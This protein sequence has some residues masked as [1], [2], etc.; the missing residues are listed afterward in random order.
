M[1]LFEWREMD[2]TEENNYYNANKLQKVILFTQH[3]P[4]PYSLRREMKKYLQFSF[5]F[6]WSWRFFF[7]S[8]IFS[9]YWV[10]C[11]MYEDWILL[12]CT[13]SL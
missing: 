10:P 12:T 2:G 9:L 1:T 11:C 4:N 5:V 6:D 8:A 13:V 7:K 3:L